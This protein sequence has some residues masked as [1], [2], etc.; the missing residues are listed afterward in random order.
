MVFDPVGAG[1]DLVAK[2]LTADSGAQQTG[3]VP[4]ADACITPFALPHDGG[5]DVMQLDFT[6]FGP[7]ETF[8]FSVDVDPTTIKGTEA[9][10]PGESGSVSGLEL[11]GALVE[12]TFTGGGVLTARLLRSPASTSGSQVTAPPQVALPAPVLAVPGVASV[13]ATVPSAGQTIRV[14]GPPGAS[15][16]L[17]RIEAA[18]HTSGLPGGG[19]DVDPF[20]GNSALVVGEA[21]ATLAPTGIADIPVTL[22]RAGPDAGLNY[23][24]AAFADASG[25]M[26]P[27]SAPVVLVPED[28]SAPPPRSMTITMTAAG[29]DWTPLPGA[30]AYDLVR[31]DLG[32]LRA[33]GGDFSAATTACLAD[34]WAGTSRDEAAGPPAGSGW[35]YLA[36]G[37]S[38]GGNG[39]YDSSGSGQAAPRDAD[40]DQAAGACP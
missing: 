17:V 25:H 29:I 31:G 19:F 12:A 37:L 40:I 28:C 16:R 33:S 30:A 22:T 10:G 8:S 21:S 36:R 7:N 18:L 2:C 34:D 5:W 11:T 23:F 39:T 9:P 4:P 24:V 38:C 27:V 20:E 32:V 6:G 1:G 3:F 35:F 14:G 15:V 26:G 13:P